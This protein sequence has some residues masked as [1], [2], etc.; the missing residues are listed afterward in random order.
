MVSSLRAW[1]SIGRA[2]DRTARAARTSAGIAG[3]P[4][5]YAVTG[6]CVRRPSAS[7]MPA[8]SQRPKTRVPRLGAGPSLL[9]IGRAA[10]RRRPSGS[11]RMPVTPAR[12][13]GGFR[14]GLPGPTRSRKPGGAGVERPARRSKPRA[15]TIRPEVCT[16]AI[17]LSASRAMLGSVRF[18]RTYS[19]LPF[20]TK[21]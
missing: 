3:S 2:G 1:T 4:M 8:S 6:R 7:T 21:A 19:A 10:K 11:G 13:S 15:K 18:D 14:R 5:A 20:S 17:T 12:G 16:Y 9:M